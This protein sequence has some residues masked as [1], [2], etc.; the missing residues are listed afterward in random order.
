MALGGEHFN[1]KIKYLIL[2]EGYFGKK[3]KDFLEDSVLSEKKINNLD[4]ALGEI[5]KFDPEFIINCIGKTGRP[6]VDWCEKNK[7]ATFNSNVA[8]PVYLAI[9]SKELGKRL[10]HLSSGCEYEGDKGGEGFN[11][12]DKPNFDGSIYS[13]SKTLSEEMLKNFDNVLQVRLRMPFD[14]V[15]HDRNLITKLLRYNKVLV[16]PNS[17]TYVPHFLKITKKLMDEKAT[18]IFNVVNKGTITHDEILKT[19]EKFSGKKLNYTTIS[20]EEL[21][22]MTAARRSNCVLS[23][24][25][26]ESF[27]EIPSVIEAVESCLKNYIKNEI[28][29]A[30]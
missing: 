21:D 1:M 2:G 23:T 22:K 7:S 11:E 30:K 16:A 9:A 19:Y 6:N 20:P 17:L 18:G 5:K 26:L 13:I 8:V 28:K 4:D 3:F 24:K 14:D 29:E 15:P 12:E 25:K 10:V 27:V